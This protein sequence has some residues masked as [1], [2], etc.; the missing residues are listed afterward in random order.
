MR[1]VHESIMYTSVMLLTVDEIA[2]W[3]AKSN[4]NMYQPTAARA[5][6]KE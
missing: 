6:V 2:P 3:Y 1:D 5:T 4:A